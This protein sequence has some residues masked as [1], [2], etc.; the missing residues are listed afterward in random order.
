[1]EKC[2]SAKKEETLTSLTCRVVALTK[3]NYCWE[4]IWNKSVYASPHWHASTHRFVEALRR[5]RVDAFARWLVWR[6]ICSHF[7]SRII[8]AQ[9]KSKIRVIA[10][11]LGAWLWRNAQLPNVKYRAEGHLPN[12]WTRSCSM[13]LQQLMRGCFRIKRNGSLFIRNQLI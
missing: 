9:G 10:V 3:S 5:L 2:D 11:L 13:F 12:N 4:R 7:G 6:W 8:V 1:M